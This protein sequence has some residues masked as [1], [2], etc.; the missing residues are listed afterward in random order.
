MGLHQPAQPDL[1]AY[2]DEGDA[3]NSTQARLAGRRIEVID[4]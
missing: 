1:T 4:T 2:H 3:M